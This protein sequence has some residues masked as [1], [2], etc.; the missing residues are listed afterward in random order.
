MQY[1]I[2][3]D[4]PD[5]MRMRKFLP[6][7]L[8]IMAVPSI[9]LAECGG[10]DFADDNCDAYIG[11]ACCV[12]KDEAD[13]AQSCDNGICNFTCNDKYIPACFSDDGGNIECY[14]SGSCEALDQKNE[15]QLNYKWVVNGNGPD[16]KTV[17]EMRWTSSRTGLDCAAI[18]EDTDH[19]TRWNCTLVPKYTAVEGTGW[20]V[21]LNVSCGNSVLECKEG[22]VPRVS[23]IN[24]CGAAPKG[25]YAPEDGSEYEYI[26]QRC[27]DNMTTSQPG[28]Q[29]ETECGVFGPIINLRNGNDSA[30]ISVNIGTTQLR[31]ADN[32]R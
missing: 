18:E 26:C 4:Y 29:S 14:C 28:A 16:P 17:A 12:T 1:D 13:F 23:A 27:P 11:V 20:Q 30:E 24:V 25:Y 21:T 15:P 19:N 2:F 8:L 10:W 22:C 6:T 9:S 7:L 5:P 32:Q 3:L 31:P